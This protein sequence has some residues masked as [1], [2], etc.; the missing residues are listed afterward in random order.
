MLIQPGKK[1][2]IFQ[3]RGSGF[4][5]KQSILEKLYIV[6]RTVV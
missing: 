5:A 2:E 6:R 4:R 1:N 3:N